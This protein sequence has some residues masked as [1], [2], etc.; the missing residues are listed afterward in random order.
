MQ[1]SND[2]TT[3]I[4][5]NSLNEIATFILPSNLLD[6][7]NS[8][9]PKLLEPQGIVTLAEPIVSYAPAPYFTLEYPGTY[10]ALASCRDLPIHLHNLV[11][12]W[13]KGKDDDGEEVGD[14]EDS[15]TLSR[16]FPSSSSSVKATYKFV[17]HLTEAHLPAHSL[18]WPTPQTFIAGSKNVVALFDTTV[19]GSGPVTEI[20]TIPSTRHLLKGGGVGMKGVVSTLSTQWNDYLSQPQKSLSG[21]GGGGSGIGLVAAGTWTRNISLYDPFRTNRAVSIFSV[22]EAADTI[23]GITGQGIIQTMWSPCGRYLLVAERKSHGM[24]VYDVRVEGK[25]LSWL[26]GREDP[27]AL[28]PSS[29]SWS[30]NQVRYA[31]VF[32][33]S[34]DTGF[35]VWA[36]NSNGEVKVWDSVG[37]EEQEMRPSWDWRACDPG[38]SVGASVLHPTG[39]VVATCSGNWILDDDES[40]SE[41][42]NKSESQNDD[43]KE[44]YE[45]SVSTTDSKLESEVYAG[46]SERTNTGSKYIRSQP[47]CSIKVWSIG[48]G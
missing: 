12:D 33:G 25:L 24:L 1:W 35:E 18:V 2:G 41:S 39:S 42:E 6:S 46:T 20:H 30:G 34:G 48:F 44:K 10:L 7:G 31:D 4:S 21:C 19:D 27:T 11:S 16:S 23:A 36:G 47:S 14:A 3:L 8:P 37:L 45:A 5:S 26:T 38:V 17:N 32:C 43:D 28:A 15:T 9:E 29:N 13:E 40:E 22:K